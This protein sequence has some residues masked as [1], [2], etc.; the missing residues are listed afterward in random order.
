[1]EREM[2]GNLFHYE[3]GLLFKK[4]RCYKDKWNCC[5]NLKPGKRGY[6]QVRVNYKKK[7]SLHRLVYKFHNDDWDIHDVSH[8]NDIDH[9]NE[10]KLDN[11]I[12]NLHVVTRKENNENKTYYGGD[13]VKGV[14]FRKDGRK[15]PW[16][17]Y[18]NIDGKL[19]TKCFATE[20]E[21]LECRAEMVKIHYTNAPSQ[22]P[23]IL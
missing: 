6:I 18:W 19:K 2:M 10:N 13:L 1:M 7:Y 15:K 17:A 8:D 16:Q 4:D 3:D 11:T 21:A 22:R 9:I 5:N 23:Q 20:K 12:E 14:N